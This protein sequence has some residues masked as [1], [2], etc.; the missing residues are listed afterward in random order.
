[1]A[2]HEK[3]RPIKK[4]EYEKILIHLGDKFSITTHINRKF[5]Y[6]RDI[7]LYSAMWYIGTRPKEAY[8]ALL[9]DIDTENE[10]FFINANR[11][12]TK[13]SRIRKIPKPFI[14]ILSKYLIVRKKLF[15]KNKYL[16]PS[17]TINHISRRTLQINLQKT[18]EELGLLEVDFIDEQG[19]PRYTINLY[20]F[21]KGHATYLYEETGD[22]YLVKE[23]LDHKNITTTIKFF[24]RA[25]PKRTQARIC[26]VFN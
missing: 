24:I 26:E 16:F 9:S 14:V 6:L 8:G 1:M 25:I 23:S 18:L 19:R 17:S 5:S 13:R 2:T 10:T 21:R 20:S 12:K 22:P 15:P 4:T 7:C 11:N 3:S